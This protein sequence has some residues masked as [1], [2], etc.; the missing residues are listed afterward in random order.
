MHGGL[1]T[2][3][4]NNMVKCED[5]KRYV[6][7]TLNNFS[8]FNS[9]VRFSILAMSKS[10]LAG[11]KVLDFSRILAAPLASMI[12]RDLGAEV[13]KIERPGA[14]TSESNL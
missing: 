6:T 11:V 10:V 5:K 9:A 3:K 8:V 14:P 4:S 7:L 1:C 12:L 13:W 2:F